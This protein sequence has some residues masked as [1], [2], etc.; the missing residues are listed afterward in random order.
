MNTSE[1]IKNICRDKGISF[2]E[3]ARRTGQVT[4][5]LTRKIA[6]NSMT[7]DEF[8]KCLAAIGAT[9]D[10]EI[11]DS[12]GREF[13]VIDADDRAMERIQLLEAQL[14]LDK[15]N[16]E[17]QKKLARD[18]RTELES[19]VGYTSLA[20]SRINEPEE[21][22][23]CLN[24]A[25]NTFINIEK[26]IAYS[27]GESELEVASE[28]ENEYALSVV[29]GKRILIIDDNEMNREILQ[30]V[31]E[32]NGLLTE[33]ATNG[34]DAVDMYLEKDPGYYNYIL[35]DLE[36]PVMDGYEA[37]KRIRHMSNRMRAAIPIIALTAN[38]TR[39]DKHRAIKAGIDDYLV[40]PINASR[41][42]N[43][44]ARYI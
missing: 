8:Q 34:K 18:I 14:E 9:C 16:I 23:K 38:A 33:S 32:E 39:E 30:E 7:L 42:M 44:L 4:S 3:L 11:K 12:A 19:I 31:L 40:K 5:T 24:D 2:S 28:D 35:M 6:R 43:V 1:I 36:M 26:M 25:E 27:I 20:S 15:K 10:F 41:L 37:T 29:R 22:L 21:A 13:D 17:Y